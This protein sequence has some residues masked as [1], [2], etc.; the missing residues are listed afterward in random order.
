MTRQSGR[1][2]P[3]CIEKIAYTRKYNIMRHRGTL[4]VEKLVGEPTMKDL[5]AIILYDVKPFYFITNSWTEIRWIQKHRDVCSSSLQ[6]D[7]QYPYY[8]L[9][10]VDI[11]NHNM[12]NVDI[13]D[14]LRVVY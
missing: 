3:K 14:Q 5:V 12:S 11:S 8:R 1:G 10:A 6:P 13:S 9:N 7:D 4:K 2:I